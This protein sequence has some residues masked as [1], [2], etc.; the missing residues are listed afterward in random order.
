M[1]KLFLVESLDF[2]CYLLKIRVLYLIYSNQSD[3]II[4]IYLI[5]S[6]YLKLQLTSQLFSPANFR[7]DD[8]QKHKVNQGD[9]SASFFLPRSC[10]QPHG[11]KLLHGHSP[12]CCINGGYNWHLVKTK[13]GWIARDW[14]LPWDGWRDMQLRSWQHSMNEF[15]RELMTIRSSS[16]RLG[17]SLAIT[18][19]VFRHIFLGHKFPLLNHRSVGRQL[20]LHCHRRHERQ[21]VQICCD[22]PRAPRC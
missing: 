21:R 6:K 1:N 13:L 5:Y 17:T 18:Q 19:G 20:R 3:T 15:T 4:Q 11:K 2:A 10:S 12:F 22:P 16:A 8:S 9:E 7:N 14:I